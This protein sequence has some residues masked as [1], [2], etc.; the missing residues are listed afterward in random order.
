MHKK[1]VVF[2]AL[3]FVNSYC[4]AHGFGG[5][6]LLHPLTGLDHI[7]AMIAVGAWSAQ[8]GS[9]ALY[10]VPCSFLAAMFAG[11]IAGIEIPTFGKI[12]WIIALSVILL[13]LA[14][15][16]NKK[17]SIFIAGIAVGIF[18]FSHG[19]AHG[20]EL[21]HTS[22]AFNYILG[23]SFT[24]VGLHLIGVLGGLLILE[25]TNGYKKLKMLGAITSVIG[26]YLLIK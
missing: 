10:F 20:I 1:V 24:T 14:I 18:G 23:F 9:K 11:G 26:I 5:N 4:Y 8:L 17:I 16:I 3:L 25:E 12:E 19:Y 2:I 22:N 7:L 15:W 13:G 21:P 6:G